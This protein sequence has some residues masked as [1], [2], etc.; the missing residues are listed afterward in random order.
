MKQSFDLRRMMLWARKFW[1]ENRTPF[2]LFLFVLAG[3]LLVW[4]SIFLAFR[5]SNLFTERTQLSQY[6]VLLFVSGC[7]SANFLF[8]DLREKSKAIAFLINPASSLE[9]TLVAI[10]FGVP[11]FFLGFNVAFYGIDYV[12]VSL[13]N[14]QNGTTHGLFNV[15][16]ISQYEN[17]FL[18]S[19]DSAHLLY[20]YF[21]VQSFFILGAIY[22]RKY[23]LLKTSVALFTVWILFILMQIV[24]TRLLPTGDFF[25]A[26]STY[27]VVDLEGFKII[28]LPDWLRVSGAFFFKFL[29]IPIF[30]LST[31]FRLREKQVM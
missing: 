13:G 16:K 3:L 6:A 5:N 19:A 28:S 23:S 2:F 8:G 25:A 11:V 7:L 10:F 27:R 15:L 20:L 21:A 14:I 24:L 26:T 4:Q 22:F 17:P 1:F 9:K 29:V 30:W 12:M 31:Y 18:D